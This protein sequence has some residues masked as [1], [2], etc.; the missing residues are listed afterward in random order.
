MVRPA[1]SLANKFIGHLN[2]LEKTRAKMEKLLT[3]GAIV[4]RD[5]EQVYAGLYLEAITSLERLIESLFIGLLVG[6]IAPGSSEIV[7]R[8]SFKSDRVARDV[9][10]GGRNYVDWLPY[11]YTEQRAKAF[12]RNGLPFTSL[13]RA[14]KRQ[15]ESLLYIRN[16]IAH[17]SSHSERMFEQEVIGALPLMPRERTPAGFLRSI[18]RTAPVKTQYENVVEEMVE[19]ALKLCR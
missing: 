18:F 10:F 6:R 12:F 13:D 9:V 16:V 7:Q 14:D 11:H 17:K 4:R 2:Y 1:I 19:V 5:I 8:V 15:V 3:T